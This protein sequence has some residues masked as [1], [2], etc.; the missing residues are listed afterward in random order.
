M[1]SSRFLHDSYMTVTAYWKHL[2]SILL[3]VFFFFFCPLSNQ[4]NL[5]MI[6]HNF[7]LF[8][9]I[10]NTI[11]EHNQRETH[12]LPSI[13]NYF[14][15]F[16]KF[17]YNYICFTINH[18]FYFITFLNAVHTS[19]LPLEETKLI[20]VVNSIFLMS[21]FL[22]LFLMSFKYSLILLIFNWQC[23]ISIALTF[24]FTTIFTLKISYSYWFAIFF[25]MF[26]KISNISKYSIF[27]YLFYL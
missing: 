12:Y 2:L 21:D 25:F 17:L 1:D 27:N 23:F 3:I 13:P 19:S 9:D 24:V 11:N 6:H 4:E 10:C 5:Y 20:A 7:I 15:S 16:K 18:D 8:Y 14:E 26:K 22:G